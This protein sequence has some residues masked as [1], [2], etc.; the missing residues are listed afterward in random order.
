[1]NLTKRLVKLRYHIEALGLRGAVWLFQLIP[2][3]AASAVMGFLWRK[4]APL[5]PRHKR[6]LRHLE[7]ALPET[8]PEERER[9]LSGMWDNLGRVA[10]ETFHIPELLKQDERFELVADELTRKVIAGE[11]PIV[12]VSMHSGNW[13]LCVQPP[14]RAGV[15]LAGVYQALK[16]PYADE[17][18]R[19][20]RKDLYKAGLYSKGHQ[21]ARKLVSIVRG[22][23]TVAIMSDLREVRGIRVP[24]FGREAYAT[25][26][27]AS[28]ARSC[29]VPIVAGRV[30]R[31]DGVRFLIEGRGITVPQTDDRKADI[32]AAT[33]EIHR[34][35]EGWIRE[36]PE[37]WMWIHRKWAGS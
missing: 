17:L 36:Y 8:T 15:A 33:E 1:M 14:T 5:N 31:K 2:V 9:I 3:D 34:V 10:A 6:A 12:F 13:E 28:L 25:P 4:L 23:G 29:G 22:G 27:P 37:Q 18:L 20:M 16:N 21:T 24:F 19:D 30:I 26:V 35:F 11:Q 7:L 32:Q